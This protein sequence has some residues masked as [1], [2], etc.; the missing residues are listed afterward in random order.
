[1]AEVVNNRNDTVDGGQRSGVD[2]PGTGTLLR[3]QQCRDLVD[4]SNLSFEFTHKR[5]LVHYNS[6]IFDFDNALVLCQQW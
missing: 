3:I 5:R 4:R 6:L 1:M 2:N